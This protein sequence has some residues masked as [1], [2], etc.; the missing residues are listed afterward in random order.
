MIDFIKQYYLDILFIVGLIVTLLVLY[1]K[2]R[3]DIIKKI[4]L[5]L[6]VQAEKQFGSKTGELK[7]AY[8]IDQI[9]SHLP[10]I[11]RFLFT[12]K[13]LDAYIAEGV[14]KLK[15]YLQKE[16]VTLSGYDDEIYISTI[17]KDG[18]D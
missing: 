1:K 15:E 8:V 11:L 13:E 16:D 7:Y 17:N 6:V 9:Y 4:I 3:V 5:A 10:S 14:A 12:K 18:A 2:H